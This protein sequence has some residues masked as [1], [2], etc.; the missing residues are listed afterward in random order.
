MI[1][2]LNS[3]IYA[4]IPYEVSGFS[5]SPPVENDLV[6]VNI[7]G[8]DNACIVAFDKVT[9][10]EKWRALNDSVSYSAPIIIPRG[11]VFKY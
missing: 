10:K 9:G 6:I 8:K 3:G 11:F 2:A 1:T 4:D 5:A 7:G